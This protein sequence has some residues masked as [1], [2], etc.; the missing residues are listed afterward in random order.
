LVQFFFVVFFFLWKLF[1]NVFF[2]VCVRSLDEGRCRIV[3]QENSDPTVL[4]AA[5][6]LL[7]LLHIHILYLESLRDLM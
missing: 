6:L 5:G 3:T 2:F 1:Q 4:K 7:L